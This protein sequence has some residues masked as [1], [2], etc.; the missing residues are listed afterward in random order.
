M[1]VA[2]P[3]E[4]Y[5]RKFDEAS[6]E[7]ERLGSRW[8]VLG[9][10]R[11]GMFLVVVAT[12]LAWVTN[13]A[14]LAEL[15]KWSAAG[16]FL[17]FLA[18]AYIHESIAAKIHVD[19]LR[20]QMHGDSLRRLRRDLRGLRV[21]AVEIP[22]E[23][24]ALARDLDLVGDA[25]LF[26][27]VATVR[28]PVGIELLRD[29]MLDGA[30]AK[31]VASR[32]T[33]VQ[34]LTADS[35]WR[36]RFQLICERL[37]VSEA[38][39]SRFIEWCESPAWLGR[40]GWVLWISRLCLAT[41]IVCMVA[42]ICGLLPLTIGGPVLI[43]TTVISFVLSVIFAGPIHDIFNQISSRH[44]DIRC[45]RRLFDQV[46]QFPSTSER[47]TEIQTR[48]FAAGDLRKRLEYLGALTWLAGWRRNGILF[49]P[50]L[51]FQFCFFWDIHVLDLLERWKRKNSMRART[52]FLDLGHWECLA[53]LAKLSFD[54]PDWCFP[55]VASPN[56]SATD[57]SLVKCRRLGHPLIN[58]IVRIDNDVEIGPQGTLLLVTGSNMSG[59]STLL[60]SVGLNVVLAQMGGPVCA[61]EFSLPTVDV[62]T[63]M[64]I[65]DSLVDGVSFF[66]AEL[67]RL[68]EL[69]DQAVS[70]GRETTRIQLFLL[71]EILQG[72]NSRER[73]IAVSRV[74]KRLVDAGSIGAVST[75]DLE[76][77]TLPELKSICRTVHFCES[78]EQ[79]EGKETMTFDYKMRTGVSPTTNALKLLELVGLGSI[80][81][82]NVKRPP[83]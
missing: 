80:S 36:E 43:G 52:W 72:T 37:S 27:L 15:W 74:I 33:A 76:L 11:G 75:H 58:P 81:D 51:V 8:Y 16:G 10:F 1:T 45:Y 35:E 67:K 60:R 6:E 59:K 70:I 53:A 55:S 14:E 13:Q 61:A 30:H 66:M 44:E 3:T 2:S 57:A 77:A 7:L 82:Q 20:V 41:L 28:T 5:Q 19:R 83:Q 22:A 78:F 29:W 54:H 24:Q 21:T 26:K 69:V 64:R 31:E 39:P 34:N 32:Q 23:H 71:D 25:S 62:A 12:L 9:Y 63:S 47:L 38:G 65:S 56:S 79:R 73:Q 17:A 46:A 42:M 18:L 50:Y 68:K 49:L 48:L 40:W 4:Y